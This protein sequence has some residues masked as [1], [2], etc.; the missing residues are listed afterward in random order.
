MNPILDD[1][2]QKLIRN[3]QKYSD[4]RTCDVREYS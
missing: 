4:N 1:M 2:T 3:I